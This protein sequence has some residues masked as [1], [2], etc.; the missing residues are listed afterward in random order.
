VRSRTIRGQ[1][2]AGSARS[3]ASRALAEAV[4]NSVDFGL[5]DISSPADRAWVRQAVVASVES[6][7]DDELALLAEQLALA[8]EEAPNGLADRFDRSHEA[9][10]LGVD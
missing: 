8:F 3:D 7:I 9:D 10:E 4:A 5:K 1:L 6:T 2:R